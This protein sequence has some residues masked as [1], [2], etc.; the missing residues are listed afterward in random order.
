MAKHQK[1]LEIETKV[2]YNIIGGKKWRIVVENGFK[3]AD[4]FKKR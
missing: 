4:P 2:F 3:V 1:D